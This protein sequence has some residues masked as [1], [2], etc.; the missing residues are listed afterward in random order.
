VAD[1][2]RLAYRDVGEEELVIQLERR[3]DVLAALRSE[4]IQAQIGTYAVNR[5]TAYSGSGHF[6]G[7]EACFTRAL[8]LP[9]HSRLRA[10]DL[11]RVAETVLRFA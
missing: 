3:D 8:A 7:A 11:D 1:E 6:P 4:G 2:I 10:A 9:F 5:L